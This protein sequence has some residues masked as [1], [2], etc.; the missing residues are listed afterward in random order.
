MDLFIYYRVEEAD[1]AALAPLVAAMQAQLSAAHGVRSGLKRRPD[2]KDGL[3]TWMEVYQATPPDFE[4]TLSGAL[5]AAGFEQLIS[6]P[7]HTEVFVDVA[8]CA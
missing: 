2:S 7:R 5:A 6:G 8:P 1:A 4:A 3:Q